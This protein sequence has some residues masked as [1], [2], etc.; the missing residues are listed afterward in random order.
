M[1]NA[2]ALGENLLPFLGVVPHAVGERLPPYVVYKAKAVDPSWMQDGPTGCMFTVRDSGWMEAAQFSEWFTQL[3][4][5]ATDC[6]RQ[7]ASVI[8]YAFLPIQLILQPS[9]V[10]VFKSVKHV[11]GR[12]L[13]V[14][15]SERCEAAVSK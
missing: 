1:Q 13:K 5:P 3:F 2:K 15:K 14:Y 8:L 4:L 10:S 9:H 7:T 11:W 6:L 12:Q